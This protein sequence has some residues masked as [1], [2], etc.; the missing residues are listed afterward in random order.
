MSKRETVQTF[1][2]RL[3]QSI[4]RSGLSRAQFAARSG[5][6]RS[7]L[8]QLLSDAN[9]RLPRAETI[10]RIAARH[11]ISID[12]LLGLSQQDQVAS[13][14]VPQ[15]AIEAGAGSP[16]DERL[17]RWHDEARGYKVRYVPSSLPDQIKTEAILA[18]ETGKLETDLAEAYS[19]VARARMAAAEHGESEIEV[20]SSRQA[21]EGFANGEGIWSSLSPSRRRAQ[22]EHA[23]KFVG[24]RYPAYRWFLFDGREH[25]SVPYT[26]F[27]SM[28]AA[29]YVGG[30]YFVFTSTEHIRELARH[31]DQLIR[32]ARVQ[33]HEI[34][35][36]IRNLG[37]EVR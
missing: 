33:P 11:T 36:F 23:A 27:G 21:L 13:D 29:I 10:A 15:L 24:D 35:D 6:D 3:I 20:C 37:E 32:N 30:M 4:E 9:V 22:L 31:F 16:A 14:I 8:S 5:L 7:T 1:R 2:A 19:G 18:Y 28:R 17:V 25:F 34:A 12:W 26:V